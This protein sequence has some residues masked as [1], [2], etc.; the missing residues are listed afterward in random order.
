MNC[1][2]CGRVL[3]GNQEK[4]FCG[5]KTDR[6][7]PTVDR[8]HLSA[9]SGEMS[10]AFGAKLTEVNAYVR[11]FQEDN[12]G[13]TKREACLSYMRGHKLIGTLKSVAPNLIDDEEARVEREAIQA[14]GA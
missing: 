8:R 10:R 6:P 3:Y 4:C 11:L 9:P 2:K 14:E 1:K 7:Q 12:P 5:A 13:A